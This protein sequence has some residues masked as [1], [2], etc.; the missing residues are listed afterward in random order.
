MGKVD[1]LIQF[2]GSVGNLSFFKTQDG[3]IVRRKYGPS[4]ER[5][6][7]GHRYARTRENNAEFARAGKATKLMRLAFAPQL[8]SMSDNR[9]SGRLT[10]ELLKVIKSDTHNARGERKVMDGDA[11]FLDG[12]EFNVHSA[13]PKSFPVKFTPSIDSARG[14][15]SIEVPAFNPSRSVSPPEGAT[16]FRLMSTAAV[17]NFTENKWH[18]TTTDS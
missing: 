1:S 11:G 13:L 3:Y 15:A 4:A 6:R 16:H 12:F 8:R 7:T 14:T 5:I 10:R 9:V 17:I 2:T 18:A